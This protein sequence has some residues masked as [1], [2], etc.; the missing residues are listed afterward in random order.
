[1]RFDKYLITQSESRSLKVFML[2]LDPLNYNFLAV[3]SFLTI[4]PRIRRAAAVSGVTIRA[5]FNFAIGK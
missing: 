3:N 1:M 2:P 4:T 5:V